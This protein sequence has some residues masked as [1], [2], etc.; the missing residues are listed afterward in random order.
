MYSACKLN[1]QGDSKQPWCIPFPIWNQSIV[2][3]PVLTVTSWP[4]YRF[5]RRQVR[6]SGIVIS[7]SIFHSLLW[8]T[9][10]RLWR[11]Q[12]SRCFLEFSCFFYD[13]TNVGNLTSVSSAF[14]KSSLYI[15]KFSVHILLKL[16][17]RILYYLAWMWNE[18]NCIVVWT[19]FGIAILWLWNETELFPYCDHCWVFQICWRIEYN[20]LTASCFRI[21]NGLAGIPSPPLALFIVMLPKAH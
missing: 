1:K 11:S 9:Q 7:L 6:W 10:S 5:L 3:C 12:W 17:W 15:W 14:S 19:F 4:E 16:S 13:P 20:I 2:P 8:S 21:L 18:G